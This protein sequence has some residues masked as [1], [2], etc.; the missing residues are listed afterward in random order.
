MYVR[1]VSDKQTLYS[2]SVT[3]P[4]DATGVAKDSWIAFVKDPH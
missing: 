3:D 1:L 4:A 2:E